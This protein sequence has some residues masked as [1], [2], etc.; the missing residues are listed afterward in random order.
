MHFSGLNMRTQTAFGFIINLLVHLLYRVDLQSLFIQKMCSNYLPMNK[1]VMVHILS[2]FLLKPVLGGI[3]VPNSDPHWYRSGGSGSR[4]SRWPTK[5]E[6][7]KKFH[8][9]RVLDVFFRGL[10]TKGSKKH[11][12]CCKILQF[13]V[14]TTL[15]PNPELDLKQHWPKMPDPHG[16][17]TPVLRIWDIYPGSE[18]FYPWSR[19]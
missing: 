11:F 19:I 9:L 1:Y 7:V 15:Y 5:H 3:S 2:V 14:S 16:I 12:F 10:K 13:L 4:R 6:K 17:C 18:F 8:V